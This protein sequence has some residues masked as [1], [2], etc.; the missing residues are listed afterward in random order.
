M[1]RNLE[2]LDRVDRFLTD[3]GIYGYRNYFINCPT[4]NSLE[5]IL[6][7]DSSDL[8]Q[9]GITD[10]RKL[11]AILKA[12]N[13]DTIAEERER[14]LEKLFRDN[15]FES[16]IPLFRKEQAFSVDILKTLT[17][18]DL[19]DIGIETL[20]ERK[21]L[22]AF[23]ATLDGGYSSSSGS[24]DRGSSSYGNGTDGNSQH[25]SSASGN[26][27]GSSSPYESKEYAPIRVKDEGGCLWWFLG[28]IVPFVVD[29]IIYLILKDTKPKTAHDFGW[30]AVWSYLG[31]VVVF[32]FSTCLG[33][34]LLF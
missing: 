12:L 26:G 18:S 1:I 22:C 16:Y 27:Q 6:I 3:H 24:Q 20:G 15:G 7:L 5:D 19:M 14:E 29:L 23:F 4:I 8:R 9:M 33:G 10:E 32:L 17:S 11:D 34:M 28:F 21:R 25:S 30:G 2:E 13:K 31:G